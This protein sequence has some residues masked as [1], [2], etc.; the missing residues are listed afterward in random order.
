M[1]HWQDHKH[2]RVV[3]TKEDVRRLV[4]LLFDQDR[5]PL[6]AISLREGSAKASVDVAH[7]ERE[8]EDSVLAFVLPAEAT[9]WLTDRLGDRRLSVHSGWVRVYPASSEWRRDPQLAPS[10]PPPGGPSPQLLQRIVDAALTAAFRSDFRL[11]EE[12]VRA[13]PPT[14][15]TVAN[16]LSTVQAI[17]THPDG[18]QAVLRTQHLAPGLPAER[19]V[20][21]GQHLEGWIQPFGLLGE[22]IPDRP[23]DDP[24]QRARALVEDGVVTSALASEVRPDRV[25][26]LL[27]PEVAVTLTGRPGENLADQVTDGEVVTVEVIPVDGELVAAFSND[28]PQPAMSVLPDGPPWL[29]PEAPAAACEQTED[30]VPAAVGPVESASVDPQSPGSDEWLL[31]VINVL[32]ERLAEAKATV[33]QLRRQVRQSEKLVVPR[34]FSDDADQLRLE[35]WLSYLARVEEGRRAEY[36]WPA[37]VTLG[38]DFVASVGSLVEAGGISRQKIVDVCAEVLC[39]LARDLPARAV[40]EWRTS[41]HGEQLVRRSDGAPAMRVRLQTGAAAA[42][43]LRYWKLPSGGIELDRV[44]VHD[45]GI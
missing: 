37:S 12:P 11:A 30:T 2:V 38:A 41:V 25:R 21:P 42:R 6:L 31:D 26:L 16:V 20:R 14:S 27:H 43:R 3:R 13:G 4:E 34:V 36:P 7:L 29:V 18:R 9:F 33:K 23:E 35:M 28:E 1:E 44:G 8:L 10:F 45:F 39:G 40:K 24:A 17:V 15:V 22:F 5:R 32:E 19:V